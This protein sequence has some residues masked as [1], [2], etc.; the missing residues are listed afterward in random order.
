MGASL[1]EQK[2]NLFINYP[3]RDSRFDRNAFR[4]LKWKTEKKNENSLYCD[5]KFKLPGTFKYFYTKHGDKTSNEQII[6][7]GF[8]LISPSL[9]ANENN[10]LSLNEILCMTVRSDWLGPLRTWKSKLQVAYE[11]GF[12]VIHFTPIQELFSSPFIITDHL[13]VNPLF[14]CNSKEE[15]KTLIDS[16]RSEWSLLSFTELILNEVSVNSIWL[17]DHSNAVI[18]LNNSPHLRPAF[19]LDK[20]LWNL[21][22][23]LSEGK[24]NSI[25]LR[26]EVNNEE[27]L[28]KLR[29]LL[30]EQY[31]R[32][33]RIHE[34]FVLDSD[35][36]E[37]D[38]REYLKMLI[39]HKS[40]KPIL[41]ENAN[42]KF[43]CHIENAEYKR[44][45]ARIDITSFAE[46]AFE[47]EEHSNYCDEWIDFCCSNFRSNINKLNGKIMSDITE[48]LNTVIDNV[49]NHVNYERV[50]ENGPKIPCVSKSQPLVP[51]YFTDISNT[52]HNISKLSL[53]Q[54]EQLMYD[55][56]YNAFVMPHV[57][58]TS[59]EKEEEAELRFDDPA[60]NSYFRRNVKVNSK[61]VKINYIETNSDSSFIYN[62]IE[63]YVEWTVKTF[64]GFIIQNIKSTPLNALMH[65]IDFARR[66]NPDIYVAAE[67]T[68]IEN[69]TDI[70]IICDLGLNQIVQ[71]S[72]NVASVREIGSFIKHHSCG[73]HILLS[74]AEQF[75]TFKIPALA[76]VSS[77][78][79][80]FKFNE[81]NLQRLITSTALI[82]MSNCAIGSYLAHEQ[83]FYNKQTAEY[84]KWN[85]IYK[86][87]GFIVL[88][89][90]LNQLHARLLH[91]YNKLYVD[92]VDENVI[93]ISRHNPRTY[94]S[95]VLIA[96]STFSKTESDIENCLMVPG[97]INKIL[98]QSTNSFNKGE[99]KVDNQFNLLLEE[100]KMI[101]SEKFAGENEVSFVDFRQGTI[102][103]LDISVHSPAKR[104][105]SSISGEF[106]KAN[107][108]SD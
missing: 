65:F 14:E 77:P 45:K 3:S 35:A 88:R 92:E 57:E 17:H 81:N 50:I 47:Q 36:I 30:K 99:I 68:K 18:N 28:K 31:L 105:S 54:I 80:E 52:T 107:K 38:F 5:V 39:S 37:K 49:I 98:L 74:K 23:D 104:K 56:N 82:T 61:A 40:N 89:T 51:I 22:I 86:N 83:L 76:Y 62:L 91:G 2:I 59:E 53:K 29:I 43:N 73:K 90:Y 94:N 97:R 44:N 67:M 42:Q 72:F 20:L 101:K 108:T 66:L 71:S 69:E 96:R 41:S 58:C 12:N 27:H 87:N 10:Q 34:L 24:Y 78:K 84:T 26:K 33:A 79:D 11:T 6:G 8:C 32:E 7:S 93:A 70:A 15:I 102:M 100:T 1:R 16:L 103:I 9:R 106:L 46:K 85:E 75:K 4:K 13:Q 21:S 95:V 48:Q 60:F 64:H 55:P 63:K 25:G 19:L